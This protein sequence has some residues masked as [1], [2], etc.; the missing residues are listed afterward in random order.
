M[1]PILASIKPLSKGGT[2]SGRLARIEARVDY[3]T[4]LLAGIRGGYGVNVDLQPHNAIEI[5]L[6]GEGNGD[7][8][9]YGFQTWIDEDGHVQV[10]AGTAQA[11][12]GA[13][14]IYAAAD[15]G[16]AAAGYVY[17]VLDLTAAP[18]E[19]ADDL[20]FGPMTGQDPDEE[21]W[22]PIAAVAGS[23]AD[24]WTVTQLHWGNIVI[25]AVTDAVDVQTGGARPT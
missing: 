10:A 16:A 8:E 13:V 4:K 20:E 5:S 3:L 23:A 7:N 11:W 17:A 6:S 18:P 24:G 12:G 14:K 21:V 1:I 2:G 25:P 9:V 22:V 15:L 19:W